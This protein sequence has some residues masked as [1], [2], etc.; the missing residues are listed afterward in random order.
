MSSSDGLAAAC[1]QR[2]ALPEGLGDLPG[3]CQAL[4]RENSH[5]IGST[6]ILLGGEGAKSE[7]ALN[8][9]RD[10]LCCG[11]AG[12]GPDAACVQVSDRCAGGAEPQLRGRQGAT[13]VEAS[14]CIG[15]MGVCM[16]CQCMSLSKEIVHLRV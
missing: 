14:F 15:R 6:N 9:N 2:K 13:L 7:K 3:H 4:L 8:D 5:T 10:E 16:Y 1:L 11:A 12:P